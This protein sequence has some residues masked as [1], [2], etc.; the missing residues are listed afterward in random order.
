[1][2]IA[3]IGSRS[4]RRLEMV[5]EWFAFNWTEVSHLLTGG[6]V[7]VDRRA[8]ELAAIG[9]DSPDIFKPDYK[10]YPVIDYG[11]DFAPKERNKLIVEGAALV[12]A[13]WD[14]RST[15]TSH[16]IA[17]AVHKRKRLHLVMA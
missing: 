13:F 14:G 15:G 7:G 17:W 8:E 9:G 12:V 2:N 16:A 3:V 10:R 6:A 4:F 11:K 5:D 1:M